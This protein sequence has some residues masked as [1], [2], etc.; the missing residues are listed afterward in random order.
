MVHD[1]K[2]KILYLSVSERSNLKKA[3]LHSSLLG[4]KLISFRTESSTKVP[5]YHTNVILSIGEDFAVVNTGGIVEEDREK[6]LTSLKETGKSI[7]EIDAKQAEIH[8]CANII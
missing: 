6:I 3:Q 7:I 2:N 4:Y 8:F 5:F 1:R